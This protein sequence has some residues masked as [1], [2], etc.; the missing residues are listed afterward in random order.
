MVSHNVPTYGGNVEHRRS[1]MNS[2]QRFSGA[3]LVRVA[4]VLAGLTASCLSQPPQYQPA[5]GMGPVVP[6]GGAGGSSVRPGVVPPGTAGTTTPTTA[7]VEG[8]DAAGPGAGPVA[9][10]GGQGPVVDG[11]AVPDPEPATCGNGRID[12]GETCDPPSECMTSCPEITCTRQRLVGSA[13]RCNVRCEEEKIT[14]CANG[15]K[16][17]P[18]ASDPAC[19]AVN[20]AECSAVCDNGVIESGE[21]CDPKS[22]CQTRVDSCKDDRDTL[23]TLTGEVN[24]CTTACTERKRPCQAGDGQCPTSCTAAT[25]SECSGCGNGRVEEGETCDPPS[26]CRSGADACRDD[27]ETLRAASGDVN[28]CTFRCTER[29]RPC[30]ANDG[31]CPSG[32]NARND[33]D[34]PGC[35]NNRLDSGELCDPCNNTSC[36]SDRDTI[37]TASGSAASCNFRCE[38]SPRP[39][40]NQSDGQCPSNCSPSQDFDCRRPNG[41]ECGGDGECRNGNCEQGVCCNTRCEDGCRSCRNSGRVGTCSA[42]MASEVCENSRDDNC[43]GQV[44]EGCCGG[45][46]RPCC[47]GSACDGNLGCNRSNNRCQNTNGNGSRCSSNNPELC[48]SGNCVDDV[49]CRSSSCPSGTQCSR[50]GACLKRLGQACE[51]GAECVSNVCRSL[52][53][54]VGFCENK[55]DEECNDD[56]GGCVKDGQ[57]FGPC[58]VRRQCR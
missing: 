24:S 52:P 28:S 23:R 13:D 14:A 15:D 6:E 44:D 34:C 25:D 9:D 10:G 48:Q 36:N 8:A 37:R 21:T 16:C 33:A 30:Q 47:P 2:P 43:N 38:S 57:D 3:W 46:G 58:L 40:S 1:Q 22:T 53:E 19:T 12:P 7:G 51:R 35:G 26:A 31:Q 45:A 4:L 41:E 5:G 55:I 32:C 50:G 49:C 27:A 18:R 42:P 17:C 39:C 29:K 54:D 11:P 56:F 20:D